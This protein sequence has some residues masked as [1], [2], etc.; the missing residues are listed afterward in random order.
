V[1]GADPDSP[2]ESSL[3]TAPSTGTQPKSLTYWLTEK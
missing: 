2:L 1:I 3:P